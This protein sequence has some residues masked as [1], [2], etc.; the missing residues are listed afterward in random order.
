VDL[1][2][3]SFGIDKTSTMGLLLV[4]IVSTFPILSC[5]RL[6]FCVQPLWLIEKSILVPSQ[7]L[8]TEEYEHSLDIPF[9]VSALVVAALKKVFSMVQA[10][11]SSNVM[12]YLKEEVD[13]RKG[14]QLE[15]FC[16]I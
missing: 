14:I 12:C 15:K 6:S 16:Q 8:S 13:A 7:F 9:I 11:L 10:L 5:L 1:A 3:L 4:S 2:F